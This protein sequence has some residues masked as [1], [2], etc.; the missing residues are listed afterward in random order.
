MALSQKHVETPHP[1]VSGSPGLSCLLRGRHLVLRSVA[2]CRNLSLN[3]RRLPV[4]LE[5]HPV[6]CLPAV[7]PSHCVIFIFRPT[8]TYLSCSPA[9]NLPATTCPVLPGS[10]YVPDRLSSRKP[11]LN[12][13][14]RLSLGPC[15]A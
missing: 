15:P 5:L 10:Y 3:Y 8:P 4:W 12:S 7:L 11:I 2:L 13:P 6:L 1:W 14:A 9:I